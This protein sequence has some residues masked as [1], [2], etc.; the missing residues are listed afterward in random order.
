MKLFKKSVI[1]ISV[2]IFCIFLVTSI[3]TPILLNSSKRAYAEDTISI[4]EFTIFSSW[5]GPYHITSGPDNNIWFTNNYNTVGRITPSGIISKFLIPLNII[6]NNEQRIITGPD[7]NLW[8]TFS[9]YN[10]YGNNIKIGR[11]TP[12]GNFLN[13]LP[14]PINTS[15]VGDITK[16][17]DGNVWFAEFSNNK[18]GKI[19]PDG[20]FHEYSI[21][22]NNSGPRGITVG[23]DG[24]IWFTE[25]VGN[26][27]GRL[28]SDGAFK[29][30]SIPTSN[31]YPYD[32]TTDTDGNLWFT[33]GYAV[34]KVGRISLDGTIDEFS[35]PANHHPFNI[36]TGSD[37]NLWFTEIEFQIRENYYYSVLPKI[38]RMTTSGTYSEFSIPSSQWY[39][40]SYDW[41]EDI[42]SGPDGNIWF[43]EKY[44]GKIGRVNL[45]TTPTS[46]PTPTPSEKLPLILIPGIMGSQFSVKQQIG[47]GIE[48]ESLSANTGK[49]EKTSDYYFYNIGDVV[50]IN[51]NKKSD[52]EKNM[53]PPCSNYLDVLQ[54]SSKL[55]SIGQEVYAQVGLN[56]KITDTPYKETIEYL[57]QYGYSSSNKNLFIFPYDWRKDIATQIKGL[58]DKID[59]ATKSAGTSKVQILA[60]SMG[61]LVAREYIRNTDQAQKVDTLIELGTPHVGTSTFLAQLLY[62]RCPIE[63]SIFWGLWS[64]C[65]LN[66]QEA[67]KL[68]QNFPGAF[69]LLPS[70]HYY[71]LYSND[72]DYPF[73][74]GRNIDNSDETT[75]ALNYDKLKTLLTNL[76]KQGENPKNMA[77]FEI[78][79]K[80]HDALDP[81]YANTNGVKT[82]LIAGTGYPTIGQIHE[83]V[84]YSTYYSEGAGGLVTLPHYKQYAKSIN[85]DGTVPFKSATLDQ[86]SNIWFVKQEHGNLPKDNVLKMAYNLLNGITDVSRQ[87]E[88]VQNVPF[89][90]EGGTMTIFS[91]AEL[92]AYDN[93]GNHTGLANDGT[94]EKN[95][96]GSFYNEIGESKSIYLPQGGH[97]NITT[98]ATG[99]GSFTLSWQIYQ[100]STETKKFLY[101]NVQQTANT[102]TFMSLDADTPILM[103]DV[104]GD[105][106]TIQQ[107]PPTNILTGNALTDHTPPVTIIQTTG[108]QS[109]ENWYRSNVTVTLTAQDDNSGILKTEYSIDNGKT[110][111]TYTNPVLISTEGINN[112]YY[113]SVDKAGNQEKPKELNVKI[114]AT[115]PEIIVRFN[116]EIKLLQATG[117]D[118]E[119]GIGTVIQTDKVII[120]K[121]KAGNTTQFDIFMK[122]SK[123][124]ARAGLQNM[125]INSLNY[126]NKATTISSTTLITVWNLDKNNNLDHLIQTFTIKGQETVVAIYNDKNDK[127]TI[128]ERQKRGKKEKSSIQGLGIIKLQTEKGKLLL[129]I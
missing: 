106:K 10:N 55:N 111:Q 33:T 92:H 118:E 94:V 3:I 83:E 64:V 28:S 38:G 81:S 4:D 22:T 100:N 75:G 47:T 76:N 79:E 101:R 12:D 96:P 37:G 97:Y 6:Y 125:I 66:G 89:P 88:G 90:F 34:G 87:P 62:N 123:I 109:L 51:E 57:S 20:I 110:F 63:T 36:T 61:G 16:G 44:A 17:P 39:P 54:L 53:I 40:S 126:N 82:Y 58:N 1:S 27:I 60:H 24:N 91:P 119:S 99:T 121:D 15:D 113:Y 2:F 5:G 41:S 50:W 105:G 23:Y 117:R 19:T 77:L 73:N 85:G 65:V 124:S 46:T 104:N 31:S 120:V 78:A 128:I 127:T 8:F 35:I 108:T 26:K 48:K 13:D 70:K 25:S 71:Q 86:Q 56:G 42:A 114:D 72:E 115:A 52:I 14:I 11:I 49:C 67:N 30:Y 21:P 18:I 69:E 45:S 29:E 43:T 116:P 80:F 98:K 84:E 122:N 93:Q 32:I 59:E 74:D 112:V 68:V 103:V 95:I 7:S 102:T 129:T 9:D 107:E